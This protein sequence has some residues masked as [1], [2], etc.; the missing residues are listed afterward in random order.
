MSFFRTFDID[1]LI[2][3]TGPLGPFATNCYI[4]GCPKSHQAAIID[5]GNEADAVTEA[6]ADDPALEP[7]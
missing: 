6:L 2:L 5:P 4:V 1:G 7:R 3:R